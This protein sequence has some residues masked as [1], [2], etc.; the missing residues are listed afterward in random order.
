[1]A[2]GMHGMRQ[3]DLGVHCAGVRGVGCTAV[4]LQNFNGPFNAL[5]EL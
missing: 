5:R 1:M 4:K 2:V 3:R